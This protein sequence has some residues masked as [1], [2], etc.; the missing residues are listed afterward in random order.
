M[1]GGAVA[2]ASAMAGRS[3]NEVR[4]ENAF[5]LRA[6]AFVGMYLA[7]N[8]EI[9]GV[10]FIGFGRAVDGWFKW[11]TYA[12]IWIMPALALWRGVVSRDRKLMLAGLATALAT[13]MTNKPYLGQPQQ[14]W[15]P[16]L[17][18]LWLMVAAVSL[19]RWLASGPDGARGGF[20][21][22]GSCT[23]MATR[24]V[25]PASHRSPF[26]STPI[27]RLRIRHRPSLAGDVR[28]AAERGRISEEFRIQNLEVRTKGRS[29]R[30]IANR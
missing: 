4:M 26:I 21:P 2:G 12:L 27:V 7:V 25:L 18:G 20:T 30:S 16:M 9:T 29:N 24:C 3:L 22:P 17:F 15:D 23:A 28:A 6:A 10:R 19:R 14:T 1:F 5:T 11:T 13:L 8:L